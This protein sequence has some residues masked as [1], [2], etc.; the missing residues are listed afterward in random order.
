MK[1]LVAIIAIA[2]SIV[3]VS[4]AGMY[5]LMKT[6]DAAPE[7]CS[8]VSSWCVDIGSVTI[9]D[10]DTP[11]NYA[12]SCLNLNGFEVLDYMPGIKAQMA[13]DGMPVTDVTWEMK[14]ITVSVWLHT[15][16]GHKVHIHEALARIGYT[17][18]VIGQECNP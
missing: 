2:L 12:V 11:E 4:H 1:K 9:Y 15:S 5:G 13:S 6:L 18:S 10:L 16:S 17:D 3:T 14:E 7:S 8:E